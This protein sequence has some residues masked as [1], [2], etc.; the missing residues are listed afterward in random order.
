M[1]DFRAGERVRYTRGANG[2]FLGKVG[3]IVGFYEAHGSTMAIVD[4]G[5]EVYPCWVGNID[6]L[7]EEILDF[8]DVE[9][10]TR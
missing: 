9:I 10:T 6:S 4:F 3:I 7:P 2:I 8:S 5:Q 1:T